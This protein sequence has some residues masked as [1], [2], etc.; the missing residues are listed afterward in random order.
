MAIPDSDPR[1]K[2][3]DAAFGAAMEGPAKPRAEAKT[4]AEVDR[5]A[6]FGR[7]D[8]GTPKAP[9]GHTKDGSVRRTAG[10]RRPKDEQPRV[11]EATPAGADPKPPAAMP[12][13]HDYS[14]DLNGLGDTIW[15]GMSFAAKVVPK[16]PL[17]G[18]IVPGEKLAAEAFI[19]AEAKSRLIGAVNLAAQHN[20]KA[21]AFC[22]KLEGGDGL[23]VLSCMFMVMP[24]VSVAMTVWKGD[25]RELAEAEL[26]SLAEM[27]KR[28]DEKMGEVIARINAQIIA[29]TAAAMPA[30]Q[31][32]EAA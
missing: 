2:D 17:L 3:L 25:K 27:A 15:L 28:N 19:L 22:K 10:G 23:W 5:D 13:P 21:A 12:E 26:P 18:K 16:I 6:P 20:A 29:A 9:H 7:E 31:T 30:E 4:P 11:A 32:A 24:V 1:A 8:D 14:D